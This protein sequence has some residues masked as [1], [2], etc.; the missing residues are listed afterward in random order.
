RDGERDRAV[1]GQAGGEEEER[2]RQVELELER[3]AAERTAGSDRAREQEA[4][5]VGE[6]EHEQR[7]ADERGRRL[8]NS[9]ARGIHGR[10]LASLLVEKIAVQAPRFEGVAGGERD[11]GAP[12]LRLA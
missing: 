8:A 6:G 11:V 4:E 3:K 2:D 1:L 9:D 12:L 7:L 5:Q 10:A